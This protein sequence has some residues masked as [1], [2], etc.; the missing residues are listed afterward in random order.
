[1]PKEKIIS[2]VKIERRSWGKIIGFGLATLILFSNLI[3]IGT[4]QGGEA[5]HGQWLLPMLLLFIA[6]IISLFAT[7]INL[8]KQPYIMIVKE[9][10]N[11]K[12]VIEYKKVK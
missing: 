2:K 10:E 8:D 3:W 9:I 7:V 12:Q 5:M 6:V 1:M 11:K 4:I